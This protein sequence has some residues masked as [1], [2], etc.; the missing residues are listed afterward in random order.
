MYIYIYDSEILHYNPC[1]NLLMLQN[2]SFD[3]QGSEINKNDNFLR[4]DYCLL[5]KLSSYCFIYTKAKLQ[6]FSYTRKSTKRY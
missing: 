2:S 1:F 5:Q 6:N 3:N 4:F